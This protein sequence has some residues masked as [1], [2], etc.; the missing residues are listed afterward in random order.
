VVSQ[1]NRSAKK[2]MKEPAA[3]KRSRASLRPSLT[4]TKNSEGDQDSIVEILKAG[5]RPVT[6]ENY[7]ALYAGDPKADIGWEAE[8][9]LPPYLRRKLP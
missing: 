8:Q 6:R 3:T 9:D 2:S 5:S 7:L 4:R 1:P